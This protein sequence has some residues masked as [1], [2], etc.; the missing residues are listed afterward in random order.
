MNLRYYIFLFN[1]IAEKDNDHDLRQCCAR[2]HRR[3][4][5]WNIS[6]SLSICSNKEVAVL[7]AVT[8][9]SLTERRLLVSSIFF[10]RREIESCCFYLVGDFYFA[11]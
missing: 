1:L 7:R 9:I 5:T 8:P 3:Q 11:C 2:H 6:V 4:F 10:I